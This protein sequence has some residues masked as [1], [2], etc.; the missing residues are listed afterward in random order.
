[1][2]GGG[3]EPEELTSP[4]ADSGEVGH[5]WPS[6]IPGRQAVLFGIDIGDGPSAAQLA[7]LALETGE[8]TGNPVPL[9][10]GVVVKI[11][12][13]ANFDIADNGR[14]VY[15]SGASSGERSLVWV[16]RE[17]RLEPI[18]VPRLNYVYARLSPDGTEVAL[19]SRDEEN[20]LWTWDFARGALQPLTVRP[21]RE[22]GPV[23]NHDGT[24]IA[25]NGGIDG[26]EGIDW[27]AADG[28]GTAERLTEGPHAPTAF[29]PD[30]AQLLFFQ[31]SNAPPHDIGMVSLDGE[32]RVELLLEGPYN[33]RNAEISP[34]G[35][36]LA[37]ES[38]ESGQ[39]EIYVRPFP[40]VS[41]S[42][43]QV[44]TDGGTRPL[45][46]GDGREL[47]Y[48]VEP[49]TIM[50]VSVDAGTDFTAGRPDV[51]VQGSFPTAV[52]VGRHYDVSRDGDRFLLITEASDPEA[53]EPAPAQITVVLNWTQELLERVPVN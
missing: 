26:N 40:D 49:S 12:G 51:A 31:P 18:N 33:E 24:R 11:T 5:H 32:R 41:A 53:E 35:N 7:V 29:T 30:G 8:V 22:R 3:G 25:Y 1:M 38:D 44:S 46:S 4:D 43:E 36:W 20:G 45:W 15:A 42:R 50:A 34:D 6:V 14:L 37:Y 28:S 9:L 10:E 47:F 48:W 27:Q 21:G 19:D 23:W 2:P 52:F 17:G 39:S 16:D 13:S